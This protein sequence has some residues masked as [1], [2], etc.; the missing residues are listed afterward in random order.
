M[1]TEQRRQKWIQHFDEIEKEYDLCVE[2]W[3]KYKTC[4]C[5]SE[6]KG[7]FCDHFEQ[8]VGMSMA[9]KI[10]DSWIELTAI[11]KETFDEM[12]KVIKNAK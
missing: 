9:V 4:S 7:E 12:K 11:Q 5:D 3:K 8:L 2:W 10:T 1:V 6:E